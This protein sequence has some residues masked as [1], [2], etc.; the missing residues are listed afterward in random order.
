MRRREFLQGGAALTAAAA[1]PRG[2]FANAP[3]AP[4]PEAWR[5]FEISTR[6]EIAKPSGKAQ[7]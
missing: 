6:V 5:K 4:K 7:A 3:F 2:A 1:L